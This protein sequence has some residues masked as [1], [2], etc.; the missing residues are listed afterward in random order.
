MFILKK[1]ITYSILPPGI[2]ILLLLIGAIILRKRLRVFLFSMAALLYIFSIGPTKNLFLR[3]LENVYKIPSVNS[4]INYDA[5]VVLG[6]GVYDNVPDID[7]K[8]FPSEDGLPRI[9]C[10]FRLFQLHK[11]PIIYSGGNV[12]DR[13]PESEVAQRLLL[14]LGVDARYIIPEGKSKDTFENARYIKELAEK[15]KISKIVLITNAYH[16]K[17]SKMLF[18]KHFK[19][20]LP[21]PA[22]YK[23]SDIKYDIYSYMPSAKN[24]LDI[25][26][27]LKEYLGI[28][29]YKITL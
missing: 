3:P 14:S 9:I 24:I 26:T 6:G 11:K 2:F 28:L 19:E 10:A 12:G 13:Q 29:F 27:A 23:T 21:F 16:M 17:R 1:L 7:G 8:G 20:I 5:Y 4:V 25:S 15:H 18:D 22:G